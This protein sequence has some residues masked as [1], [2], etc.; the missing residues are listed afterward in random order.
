M[1]SQP[2]IVEQNTI[3]ISIKDLSEDDQQRL[4]AQNSRMVTEFVAGKLETDSRKNWDLFYKRN[5]TNFFKDRNW[6]TREF[7]E[8][9]ESST[10]HRR[11][12]EVGCGVGNL[13]FPLLDNPNCRNLFFFACDFSARAVDFVKANPSYD[14]DRMKAFQCDITELEQF[15]GHIEEQSLDIISMIFVLSAIHPSKF[16]RVVSNLKHL[17]RPGGIILFRDYGR[18]DMAQLR[19]KSGSKIADNFYVRQDG[20]R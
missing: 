1:E 16:S 11:M 3:A 10:T 9:L 13:V 17:L 19:F 5:Q 14:E 4:E 7:E 2:G 12:L 8:L 20:T 6:T 18:Y 15:Q